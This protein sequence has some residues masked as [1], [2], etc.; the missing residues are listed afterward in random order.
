ME[1]MRGVGGPTRCG[2]SDPLPG[3]RGNLRWAT[4]RVKIEPTGKN[5]KVAMFENKIGVT[6]GFV[7]E[8]FPGE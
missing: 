6:E 3:G 5:V 8:S 1:G 7:N 4:L 2:W